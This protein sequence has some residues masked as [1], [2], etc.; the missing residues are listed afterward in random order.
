MQI[1]RYNFSRPSEG[2]ILKAM[3]KRDQNLSFHRTIEIA[4]GY[5]YTRSFLK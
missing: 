2:D 4:D 1:C 5:K 3:L